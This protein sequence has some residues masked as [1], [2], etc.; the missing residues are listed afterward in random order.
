MKILLFHGSVS[1]G[2][3]AF[4]AIK[5]IRYIIL[6]EHQHQALLFISRQYSSPAVCLVTKIG[7]YIQTVNTVKH[8]YNLYYFFI[9]YQTRDLSIF[10]KY[11]NTNS[12]HSSFKLLPVWKWSA[13]GA[14]SADSAG[15][16]VSSAP[17][18]PHQN[19]SWSGCPAD[20][21]SPPRQRIFSY[22]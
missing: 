13:W 21:S 15:V 17:W 2:W 4:C 5:S 11:W 10:F 6:I 19:S 18:A 16:E 20:P 8:F 22:L 1:R 14:P 3:G 9:K 12:W 7:R